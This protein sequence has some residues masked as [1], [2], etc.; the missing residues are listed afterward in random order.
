MVAKSGLIGLAPERVKPG[1]HLA[2]LQ[3]CKISMVLRKHRGNYILIGEC[4]IHGIMD[5]YFYKN[6]EK[7]NKW[8]RSFRII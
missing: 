3:G 5:G 4:Y 2:L 7:L 1:D 6:T 8:T